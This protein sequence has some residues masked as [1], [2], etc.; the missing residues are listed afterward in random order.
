MTGQVKTA[1]R[2]MLEAGF[3]RSEFKCRVMRKGCEYGDAYIYGLDCSTERITKKEKEILKSGL[4]IIRIIF[5]DGRLNN[6]ISTT[7]GDRGRV[8]LIDLR[9]I[10]NDQN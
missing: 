7:Y 2:Q 6:T 1:I 4:G 9:V 8:H 3:K 5:K 10:L